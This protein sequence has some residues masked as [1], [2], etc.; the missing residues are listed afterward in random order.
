MLLGKRPKYVVA[1]WLVTFSENSVTFT[2]FSFHSYVATAP[3]LFHSTGF[4]GFFCLTT[5]TVR[6]LNENIH[7]E[8]KSEWREQ[9]ICVN[10]PI[11]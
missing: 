11:S 1:Q 5:R 7:M 3:V 10:E 2:Q 9:I 6:A 4:V 8:F